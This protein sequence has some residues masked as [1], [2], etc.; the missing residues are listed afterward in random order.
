V[1]DYTGVIACWL[2]ISVSISLIS[3]QVAGGLIDSLH[4]SAAT[5]SLAPAV[6]ITMGAVFVIVAMA[7]LSSGI[8]QISRFNFILAHIFLAIVFLLCSPLEL[9]MGLAATVISYSKI[10]FT[11]SFLMTGTEDEAVK[12]F[13]QTGPASFLLWWLGI[14][15]LISAYYGR[16]SYGRSIREL[17]LV[18]TIVPT[19]LMAIWFAIMGNAAAT[20]F[21]EISAPLENLSASQAVYAF[22][23]ALP[24]GEVLSGLALLLSILFLVT[25]GAPILYVLAE[26]MYESV[27][28]P[29]PLTILMWG[30]AL[31]TTTAIVSA[32]SS[33]EAMQ[34]LAI[35]VSIPFSFVY[36]TILI[37][38]LG[39]VAVERVR[40]SADNFP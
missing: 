38:F 27:S 1:S 23:H 26:F 30:I 24:L 29:S 31:G 14:S 3:Q 25:T 32:Q 28:M 12:A 17:L 9:M 20:V 37:A 15:T 40:S 8:A 2:G 18:I 13:R 21:Q 36:V 35:S 22:V 11:L 16:I 6:S 39:R 33:I 34:E 5:E 7:G 4:L 19:G 10:L